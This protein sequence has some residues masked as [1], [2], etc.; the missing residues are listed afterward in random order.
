MKLL[1]ATGVYP[2]EIGGPATHTVLLEKGLPEHGISVDVVPFR[3]VKAWPPGIRHL[4]Y[5]TIIL[6]KSLKADVVLAQDAFS[7]GFPAA[8]ASRITKKPL[9]VRIPGDHAWE[10]GRQR[11][12]ILDDLDTFQKRTYARPVERMRKI[13]RYVTDRA[14][15]VVVPSLYMKGIAEAWGVSPEKI[16]VIYNGV[17]LSTQRAVIN[18]VGPSPLIVTSARLVPWK[19][20]EGVID[21]VARIPSAQLVVLGSGPLKEELEARAKERGAEKRIRFLGSVSHEEALSWYKA[22]DVFVLNSNYEGLSH[23]LLQVM[24]Q[25]TPIVATG[26]GGNVELLADGA[27]GHLVPVG[28]SM[29]LTSGIKTLLTDTDYARTLSSRARSH[30]QNFSSERTVNSFAVLLEGLKGQTA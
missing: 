19:G 30:V 15:V 17:D 28:D 5:T 13:Q 22:A 6:F 25:G 9:V 14:D 26:I 16:V 18:N 4:L 29:A 7:V 10:Q 20:V 23:A 12:A 1:I 3:I 11:Y 2:P 24:A 8:L 21:A 27:A